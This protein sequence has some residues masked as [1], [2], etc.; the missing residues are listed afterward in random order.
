MRLEKLRTFLA[1]PAGQPEALALFA[2]LLSIAPEA[3]YELPTVSSERQ[4]EETL[5]ALNARLETLCRQRPVLLLFE[6]MH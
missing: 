4:K 1:G 2:S 6:D 3:G 5:D